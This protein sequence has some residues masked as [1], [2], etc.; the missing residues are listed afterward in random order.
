MSSHSV[1]P[2]TFNI[3]AEN[4]YLLVDETKEAAIVDCG[5]MNQAEEQQLDAYIKTHQLTPKLLLFTHLHFDHTWGLPFAAKNYKLTPMAH[6]IEI[7]HSM[8]RKEQFARFG[9]FAP[10]KD[11]SAEPQY[12]TIREGDVLK[13][14]H[15]EL[16]VLFVPGH[17]AGHVA[18]YNAK[19]GYVLTGDVLFAGDIGRSD[20]PGGDYQT[21]INSIKKQLLVLPPETKVFPGHGPASTIQYEIH[22]NPYIQ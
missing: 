17:T 7:Q 14:G 8:P 15:S 10:S 2:F 21:L 13:F 1:V 5:C 20:L 22:N 11:D 18:F 3:V 6:P 12:E 19:A 9:I 4:T 16:Q